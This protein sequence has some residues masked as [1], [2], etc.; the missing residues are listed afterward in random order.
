MRGSGATLGRF[1]LL[2]LLGS[3]GALMLAP[4]AAKAIDCE[5]SVGG[6]GGGDDLGAL[7]GGGSSW[8]ETS[9]D[10]LFTDAGLLRSGGGLTRGD[11]YDDYFAIEVGA[12]S[13]NN[14]DEDACTRADGGRTLIYPAQEIQPDVFVTP[15]LYVS[16]RR[17][18]G[19]SL[20][21]IRNAG[22]APVELDLGLVAGLGSDALTEVDRTS[23]GNASVDGADVWATSCE[24]PDS[25]GCRNVAG[26]AARDP[27][28]SH[29]WERRGSKPESADVVT[30][31]D[32]VDEV[33]VEFND[34]TVGAGETV[35][36]MGL[37]AIHPTIRPAR[38]IA[39]KL[40]KN[41]EDSGAFAGLSRGEKRQLLNW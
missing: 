32:G 36:L 31:V 20:F 12:P 15:Q 29:V 33:D 16:K 13:Y 18:L 21:K 5:L 41:P 6:S 23:S 35:S 27:E 40:A 37:G 28:L 14:P 9:N 11:A 38:A 39:P 7:L 1:G 25:D 2:A 8:W 34:V 26:E 22:G 4:S 3:V 17:A 10:A 24:D 19:R 30:F